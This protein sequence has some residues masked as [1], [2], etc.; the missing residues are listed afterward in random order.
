MTRWLQVDEVK[1]CLQNLKPLPK[2]VYRCLPHESHRSRRTKDYETGTERYGSRSLSSLIWA[3]QTNGYSVSFFF[4]EK[5]PWSW[6]G[7]FIPSWR[8]STS[9][10]VMDASPVWSEMK[11]LDAGKR[12]EYTGRRNGHEPESLFLINHHFWT[13]TKRNEK[14]YPNKPVLYVGVQEHS[15]LLIHSHS[16]LVFYCSYSDCGYPF[17]S[18]LFQTRNKYPLTFF[19]PNKFSVKKW[20]R[21]HSIYWQNR[22]IQNDV[23]RS[24]K[25]MVCKIKE[26]QTKKSIEKRRWE[27]ERERRSIC[28]G[29][30]RSRIPPKPASCSEQEWNRWE[31]CRTCA[32]LL[33]GFPGETDQRNPHIHI[34]NTHVFD[35]PQE[36]LGI[37]LAEKASNTRFQLRRYQPITTSM[38]PLASILQRQYLQLTVILFVSH[39]QVHQTILAVDP[40]QL[41]QGNLERQIP[42][43]K[44]ILLKPGDHH[45]L[46]RKVSFV[47]NV[48]LVQNRMFMTS[49]IILGVASCL[50]LSI[51]VWIIKT[52]QLNSVSPIF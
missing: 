45:V 2:I 46:N 22:N 9:E 34:T 25:S 10:H 6:S 32:Q 28:F 30:L 20:E 31:K 36:G 23:D 18:F 3:L 16:C 40:R 50:N 8:T 48:D 39:R 51:C 11:V 26:H 52:L 44:S 33:K 37:D 29:F 5:W 24:V 38:D 14:E 47:K 41:S 42:R 49:L 19:T 13:N 4:S 12:Q 43:P 27:N 1:H 17:I 35:S 7:Y 15:S 21:L